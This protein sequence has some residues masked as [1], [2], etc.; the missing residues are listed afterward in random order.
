MQLIEDTRI[1]GRRED[2][3]KKDDRYRDIATI[4]V[5]TWYYALYYSYVMYVLHFR[6][7]SCTLLVVQEVVV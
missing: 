1:E 4:R 2:D 5:F 3:N 6:R 7:C